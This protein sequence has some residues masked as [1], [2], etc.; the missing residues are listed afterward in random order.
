M[1]L[2]MKKISLIAINAKY[3]HS[4]LAVLCIKEYAKKDKNI[5][6]TVQSYTINQQWEQIMEQILA[7]TPDILAFSCYIWNIEMVTQIIKT[8]KKIAPTIKI[9]LGG[10]EV[11]YNP[12][13]YTDIADYIVVGEGEQT[14]T[15]L[16]QNLIDNNPPKEAVLIGL[17]VQLDS[18]PFVYR[19]FDDFGN[20][21]LYYETSRGCPYRC[22]YCLSANHD[23][24]HGVRFLTLDRVFSDIK[25][26]LI[27]NVRQV[28]FVD[29]T[30]NCDKQR[31]QKILEFIVENDN[32]YTNF[33]FEIAAEILAPHTLQYLKTVRK[34]L[35]QLEIGIQ[36][37]NE[38]TLKVINRITKP[39][40]LTRVVTE[41][42]QNNN[43]HIHL[44]LI[45]GLPLEG[46]KSFEQSF[47]FVYG[48]K[49]H[50][51]QLGFLKVL[52][53]SP[54]EK[55]TDEYGIV[56]S[57]YPPYQVLKTGNLTYSEVCILQGIEEMVELYYNSSRFKAT[58][59]L[60]ENYYTSP[61]EMYH[62]LSKFYKE[63]GCNMISHSKLMQHDILYK[64]FTECICE[65]KNCTDDILTTYQWCA[66][67][68]IYSHEKAKK[69][70]QW[71]TVDHMDKYKDRVY[72]FYENDTNVDKYLR[73]YADEHYQTKQLIRNAH[74]EIF[75]IN[76][77]EIIK[78]I[79]VVNNDT[80]VDVEL[81]N[82]NAI[83]FNYKQIDLLGNAQIY[84]IEI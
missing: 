3:I 45:A 81:N 42:K 34:G 47:N 74:I 73:E 31:T 62:D 53:G 40:I 56:H 38:D 25:T 69:L 43:V 11:S 48:L 28:K 57:D 60:I 32:G 9:I 29:R 17:P 64:F 80:V 20:K 22:A 41:I 30:F 10:P 18:I 82:T 12:H 46:I 76:P 14:V 79:S 61:F 84:Q 66:K 77:L 5:D 83:L 51:F 63:Q 72:D 37:T 35:F 24:T 67:Y 70:P 52:K 23:N 4:N 49:P 19:N 50:Q 55:M 1:E 58:L 8:L 33:H 75:E 71:L 44:D 54:M 7:S 13:D 21:I 27:N 59:S 16:L 65:T 2:P 39:E 26:F 15:D 68:D 36:S 6:V 78:D